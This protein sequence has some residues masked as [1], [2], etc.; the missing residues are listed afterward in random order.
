MHQ[1]A[2]VLLLF[3]LDT[4]HMVLSYVIQ[5]RSDP[6]S[7]EVEI[8]KAYLNF[9]ISSDQPKPTPLLA[10]HRVVFILLRYAAAGSLRRS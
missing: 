6:N 1:I 3:T 9:N 8:D 10:L 5:F 7:A 2:V 4:I